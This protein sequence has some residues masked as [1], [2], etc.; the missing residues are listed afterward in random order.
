MKASHKVLSIVSWL[1]LATSSILTGQSQ[2]TKS[3]VNNS[4]LGL[5]P[6]NGEK[7]NF[8]I[9]VALPS[10]MFTGA[11][12]YSINKHFSANAQARLG[13]NSRRAYN[14]LINYSIGTFNNNSLQLDLSVIGSYAQTL[15]VRYDD[16]PVF[17]GFPSSGQ[18][19]RI[20][21]SG[22]SVGGRVMI[23]KEMK[24][25][26]F[27]FMISIGQYDM[28]TVINTEFF[29]DNLSEY[30]L[31]Y[32]PSFWAVNVS[33]EIDFISP[34]K[35]VTFKFDLLNRVIGSNSFYGSPSMAIGINQNLLQSLT[36][37]FKTIKE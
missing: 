17:L 4:L 14:G 16:P 31:M 3:S 34:C 9:G 21:Q 26:R 23:T 5:T 37:K 35:C 30:L 20:Y 15:G 13:S 24:E 28:N 36:K 11:L 22:T 6:M 12:G 10:K 7:Y 33:S 27:R 32:D 18:Y 29:T 19:K 25:S 2:L 1:I 8:Y